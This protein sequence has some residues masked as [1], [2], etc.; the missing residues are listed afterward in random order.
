MATN[1]P[2]LLFAY[3]FVMMFEF[4]LSKGKAKG[5]DPMGWFNPVTF[6]YLSQGRI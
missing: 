6:L 2:Y 5:L 1:M 4:Q 3:I